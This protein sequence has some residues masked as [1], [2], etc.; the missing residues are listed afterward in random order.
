MIEH[1]ER[2]YYFRGDGT[3]SS[4]A[5]QVDTKSDPDFILIKRRAGVV[6]ILRARLDYIGPSGSRPGGATT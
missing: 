5:G 3:K 4:V 6:K 1:E 2:V